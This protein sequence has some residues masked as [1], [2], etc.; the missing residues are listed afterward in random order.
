MEIIREKVLK[1]HTAIYLILTEVFVGN[2]FQDASCLEK[3]V[4]NCSGLS[5]T[6]SSADILMMIYCTALLSIEI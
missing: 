6:I 1:T 3:L 5:N 2:E 4:M